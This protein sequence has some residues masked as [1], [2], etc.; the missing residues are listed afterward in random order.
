MGEA[1]RRSYYRW[2]KEFPKAFDEALEEKEVMWTLSI[3]NFKTKR[4]IFRMSA[5]EC[6]IWDF[7]CNSY[8]RVR[9]ITN[10]KNKRFEVYGVYL[11]KNKCKIFDFLKSEDIEFEFRDETTSSIS[12]IY[13]KNVEDTVKIIEYIVEKSFN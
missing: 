1:K 5:Y 7:N 9:V 4:E 3:D 11:Y 2:S 10:V 6:P 8:K 12:G 13:L